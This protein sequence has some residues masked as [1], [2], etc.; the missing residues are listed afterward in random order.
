LYKVLDPTV[1][2]EVQVE[3]VKVFPVPLMISQPEVVLFPISAA[4]RNVLVTKEILE[5]PM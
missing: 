3:F 5:A 1:I 4:F 2:P